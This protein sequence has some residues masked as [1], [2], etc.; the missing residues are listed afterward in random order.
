M[1]WSEIA[2]E[3]LV[4]AKLL[5]QDSRWRSAVSRS[6]YAAYASVANA[7]NGLAE[8]PENRFGPSHDTLPSLVMT[9]LTGIPYQQRRKVAE[10]ARQLYRYRVAADYEPPT[11]VDASFARLALQN[12]SFILRSVEDAGN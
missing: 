12:A 11:T 2:R 10:A 3:N 5:S 4:V 6:Y 9:Y 1:T 8:Y 7:L